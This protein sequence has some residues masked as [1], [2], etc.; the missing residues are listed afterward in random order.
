[1]RVLLSIL[2]VLTVTAIAHAQTVVTK[3]SGAPTRNTYVIYYDDSYL[4]LARHYGDH[5]DFGG[6][7]EP[8]LF[9]HSKARNVWLE[10]VKVSTKDGVFGKGWSDDK[11][12]QKKLLMISVGWDFTSLAKQEYADM[13]LRTSG[14]LCF[15][16][17]IELHEDGKKYRLGF[18]TGTGVK[19]A[20]TYLYITRAD[21]EKEFE[22]IKMP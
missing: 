13:P 10:I 17:K 12:E 18:M 15:P 21:L 20:A 3:F 14:S 11:E 22:K 19:S 2:A 1:M 9:V 6:N 8:G 7:T 4:F 16:D 5:R